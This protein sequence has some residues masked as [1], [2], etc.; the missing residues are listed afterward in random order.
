MKSA[1]TGIFYIHI[2][3]I[4]YIIMKCFSLYLLTRKWYKIKIIAY[5]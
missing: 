5:F 1:Y 3:I 2:I 4:L